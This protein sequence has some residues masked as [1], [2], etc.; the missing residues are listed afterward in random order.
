VL[1]RLLILGALLG[2]LS[3]AASASAAEVVE[4]A[5]SV[6]AAAADTTPTRPQNV[7]AA[8]L[9]RFRG[10]ITFDPAESRGSKIRAYRAYCRHDSKAGEFFAWR[11]EENSPIVVRG[12][13][14]GL[15]YTCNV[16]ARSRAGYGR[17]AVV[18]LPARP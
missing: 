17:G 15:R 6:A 9:S 11:V 2:A 16:R 10:R 13:K 4:S 14:R 8:R 3:S 1:R 18:T 12:L 5:F 7:T